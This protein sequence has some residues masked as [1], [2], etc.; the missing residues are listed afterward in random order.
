VGDDC[1]VRNWDSST[2]L[3]FLEGG[4]LTTSLF[5]PIEGLLIVE[6]TSRLGTTFSKEKKN[7]SDFFTQHLPTHG[8]KNK[9]IHMLITKFLLFVSTIFIL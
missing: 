9:T 1:G 4:I 8:V 2:I 7:L 5:N 6:S 3:S